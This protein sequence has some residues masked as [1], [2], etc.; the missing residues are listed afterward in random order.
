[1]LLALVSAISAL[2]G[3]LLVWIVSRGG[4]ILLLRKLALQ[5]RTLVDL[6]QMA[7]AGDNMGLVSRMAFQRAARAVR[8]DAIVWL[9]CGSDACRITSFYGP[10]FQAGE[11]WPLVAP[12]PEILK[13]PG[14]RDLEVRHADE[15]S[16]EF[17]SRRG[18][19]H[20]I[21]AHVLIGAEDGCL[22]ILFR[23]KP[24][25]SSFDRDFLRALAGTLSYALQ[26]NYY[27]EEL[28]LTRQRQ[29]AALN[30]LGAGLWELDL[31]RDLVTY[32]PTFAAQR[33]INGRPGTLTKEEFLRAHA[34]DSDSVRRA[35]ENHTSGLTQ[36]FV[37][38]HRILADNTYEWFHVSG[39]IVERDAAGNPLLVMGSQ[40]NIDGRKR[41]EQMLHTVNY[42]LETLLRISPIAIA[43]LRE[44]LKPVLWNPAADQVL[45]LNPR[46]PSV[47]E[48][49]AWIQSSP[50]LDGELREIELA[51]GRI[52]HL[53]IWSN[54]GHGTRLIMALDVTDELNASAERRKLESMLINRQ[55]LEAI[56]SLASGVAH[57]INNPLT[58]V[59]NF[60]QLIVDRLPPAD[61]LRRFADGIVTEGLRIS[62]IVRD[63]LSFSRPDEDQEGEFEVR[64]M[65][66]SVLGF[67]AQK[68]RKTRS[69]VRMDVAQG[70]RARGRMHQ[71]QQVFLNLITNAA[72]SLNAR[73][74]GY[75]AH[76]V[77]EIQA[78]PFSDPEGSWIRISVKDFGMGIAPDV[79]PRIFDPFFTTKP[80]DIGAGLGLSISYDIVRKHNGRLTAESEPERYAV[81]KVD[82][83]P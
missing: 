12:I 79:L 28:R 13:D 33:G 60:G 14:L 46:T 52:H 72:Y 78:L 45:G 8:A 37:S 19:T 15:K 35:F 75:D 77:I 41:V 39:Q 32:D 69:T 7:L 17:Y 21:G 3:A 22:L 9:A 16:R 6:G 43:A 67:L 70:L 71:L 20:C 82:L 26:R 44:D 49:L 63:L 58:S 65:L 59:I 51:D 48:L 30:S 38:E 18:Y 80:R 36:R 68:L 1:M 53:R 2:T 5:R 34:D 10:D 4:R 66:E 83:P 11:K 57:E 25:L 56:G 55:K 61:P 62:V 40:V 73:Y 81:F 54:L 31:Q 42:T 24:S 27:E 64:P 47:Q 50:P 76:K 23:S 29:E 74:P